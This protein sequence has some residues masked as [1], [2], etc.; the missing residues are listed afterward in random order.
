MKRTFFS[1]FLIALLT[2]L[3]S[4]V[5]G[6]NPVAVGGV[7]TGFAL[8]PKT[9]SGV[10]AALDV[11]IWKPWIRDQVFKN[12]DFLNYCRNADEHVLQGKIV[13]IPNSGS[14]S[15]ISRNRTSLP[16]TISK[17]TDTDVTY[18]LDEFTSDP[19]LITD[20]E[21]ILS[22]DKMASAMGQDMNYMSEFVADWML[23]NWAFEDASDYIIR[24]SG[25]A[26]T[27]HLSTAT[28]NRKKIALSDI[29]EAQAR[30]DDWKL[31][32]D[33]RYIMMSGRMYQQLMDLLTVTTYR[34]F[35]S[36]ANISQGVMGQLYGFNI[37][38]RAS[39]LRA[40]NDSTPV[41]KEPGAAE[42]ATDNDTI[43]C[44]HSDYVERALGEV[45]IFERKADPTY[46]GDIYSLLIRSGGRKTDYDNKGV[47]GIV[48]AAS[49]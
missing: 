40:T 33:G 10:L 6:A 46:Y 48:Q 41:A 32:A 36:L 44:W 27:A 34:D 45:K 11:E 4:S 1:F 12:N 23:Y 39:V 24:T 7:L 31:P 13:H 29:A 28:G 21:S 43:L 3:F 19:R 22:Y 17:R 20:A 18:S 14:A 30:F 5:T 49:A 38:K 8:I 2:T 16:A 42:A 25:A 26:V 35:S 9:Q 47:I 15:G 37:L